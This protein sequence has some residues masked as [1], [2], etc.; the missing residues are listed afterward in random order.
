[1]LNIKNE[2]SEEVDLI[3]ET[4]LFTQFADKKT[5]IMKQLPKT[6]SK[7]S[8][9]E[10]M[11]AIELLRNKIAHANEYANTPARARD[12]C[13]TVRELLQIRL[14]IAKLEANVISLT[15]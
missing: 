13:K 3:V 15:P 6:R 2:K 7:R 14:E 11:K 8:F 4:L 10:T 1:M 9:E 12:L 5:L